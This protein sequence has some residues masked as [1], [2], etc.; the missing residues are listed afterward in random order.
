M[1]SNLMRYRAKFIAALLA[2]IGGGLGLH[3]WYLGLRGGVMYATWLVAG[4]ALFN[5]VGSKATT[6]IVVLALLPVWAGFAES[7]GIAV[8]P[9]ARFDA[10]FNANT[11]RRNDNGWNCVIL[12]IVVLL[13]GT[14]ILMTTIILASQFYFEAQGISFDH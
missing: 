2:F 1:P 9:D 14:T 10:R 3:R 7:L 13:V 11:T 6:W 8:M 4:M 12:A 5:A